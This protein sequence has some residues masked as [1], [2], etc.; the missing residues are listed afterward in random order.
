[1]SQARLIADLHSKVK[2]VLWETEMGRCVICRRP[3]SDAAHIFVRDKLATSFDTEEDGNV[4]LLCRACHSADHGG[5]GRYKRWYTERYGVEALEALERRSNVML[6][7]VKA[8]LKEKEDELDE[9]LEC[10]SAEWGSGV[11]ERGDRMPRG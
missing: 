7:N 9:E 2:R 5:D 8:F 10:L 4:H 1:M 6:V 11:G 3:A